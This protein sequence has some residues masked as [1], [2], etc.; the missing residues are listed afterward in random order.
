M[1]GEEW[2]RIKS[3][4]EAALQVPEDARDAFL[5]SKCGNEPALH[6]TL[7]ELIKNH[8]DDSVRSTPSSQQRIFSEGTLIADRFRITRFINNGSMGEVYEAWDERLRLCIALKTLLPELS[9]D[10]EAVERFQREIL[11]A[12]NVS[13][14]NLCRVYDFVEHY[15]AP[16]HH[17]VE[18][19]NPCLTMEFVAGDSLAEMLRKEGPLAVDR[20]LVLIR[21]IAS[22]L[23]VLHDHGIVHRDLK[24]SNIMLSPRRDAGIR[25]V[26]MDFGLA[27]STNEEGI[28]FESNVHLQMGTP[29]F[30]APELLQKA[31]PNTS[32][33][34]YAFGL[35]I[36]EM[37]TRTRAFSAPSIQSLY[38]AKL[39]ED[40]V[41]PR[42]RADGLPEHWERV[43]LRCISRDS[44]NRFQRAN[45]VVKALMQEWSD[46]PI[47]E[48]IERRPLPAAQ[49]GTPYKWPRRAF[50]ASIIGA[51]LALVTAATLARMSMQASTTSVEVFEIDNQTR[52]ASNDYLCNGTT[53]ELMR[54]LTHLEGVKVIPL[55]ATRA[56]APQRLPSRFTLEGMLQ[57]Y[58]VQLRL[59]VL[60]TDNQEN[61]LVWSETFDH[62]QL[63][64]PLELQSD[65]ATGSVVALQKQ[66][67]STRSLLA[68]LWPTSVPTA[69]HL[70]ASPTNSNLAFDHYMRGRQLLEEGSA[71]KTALAISSLQRAIAEDPEFALAYSALA[72]AH[73]NM[74]NYSFTPQPE[75]LA[76]ARKYAEAAVSLAPGL[77]EAHASLAALRQT[78]WQWKEA[79]ASFLEALRIKPSYAS[80]RRRY[81]GLIL[82]FA[83]FEEAIAQARIAFEQDPYDQGAV[84]GLGLYLFLARK[85]DEALKLLEPAV[86]GQDMM[87][88][89]H[90]LGDLYAQLAS[91]S[92][93]DK[94]QQYYQK[95]FAEAARVTAIE[96]KNTLQGN[97]RSPLGDEMFAHYYSMDGDYQ[98]AEPYLNRMLIDMEQN[99]TSAAIVAWIYAAQKRNS[100][101]LDLLEQAARSKD[102]ELFYIKV[103][104]FLDTLHDEPRFQ[105]LITQMDL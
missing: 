63:G 36:D 40:P 95:A 51:P 10:R 27:K 59:S 32:S 52:D 39:W 67:M 31:S 28:F 102:R 48:G 61:M 93:G 21:Q 89:R 2:E 46:A 94:R 43:I 73:L 41:P 83:H 79:E 90:N 18:E 71:Q 64:D 50:L 97:P 56:K 33:D 26:L 54:R 20:A 98:S 37:V 62:K 53:N 84:P 57:S 1:S 49:I 88:A 44:K 9:A 65:I 16:S 14:E 19:V 3:I 75:L 86:E 25:V 30:M 91:I 77:A 81:A 72:D 35:I 80:A 60:L 78:E 8:W 13:H 47:D 69:S 38:F 104:P 76:R 66:L 24:P 101:A 96:R 15:G 105:R 74:M 58:N 7:K 92:S 100:K 22:G 68:R 82:Q 29:Y 55:H 42:D 12:R 103:M 87:G 4:F 45:D 5:L 6:E 34:I 70:N 85:Y 17:G 23:D 99:G 11:I